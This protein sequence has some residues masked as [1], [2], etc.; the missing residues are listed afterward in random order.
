[1]VGHEIVY[2]SADEWVI[3]LAGVVKLGQRTEQAGTILRDVNAHE[4][5]VH[6]IPDV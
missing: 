4:A 5:V 2:L 3:L 6:E 1:M